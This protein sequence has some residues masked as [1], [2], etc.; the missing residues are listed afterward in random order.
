M[1]ITLRDQLFPGGGQLHPWGSNFAPGE[2]HDNN[3]LPQVDVDPAAE[4]VLVV[5]LGLAV[6]DEHDL[7]S[8]L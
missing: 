4:E 8:I 6:P 2:P 1:A 7:E 5:P 3:S